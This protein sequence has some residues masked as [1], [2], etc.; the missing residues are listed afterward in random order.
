MAMASIRPSSCAAGCS[1]SYFSAWI[2]S[3]MRPL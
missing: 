2:A 3:F 1:R